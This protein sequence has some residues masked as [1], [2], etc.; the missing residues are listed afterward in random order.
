[1]KATPSLDRSVSNSSTAEHEKVARTPPP[2]PPPPPQSLGMQQKATAASIQIGLRQKE[3]RRRIRHHRRSI[4]EVWSHGIHLI[5]VTAAALVG[6]A[7]L[8][9]NEEAE[10]EQ[11]CAETHLRWRTGPKEKY[12]ELLDSLSARA[13]RSSTIHS[14]SQPKN[15]SSPYASTYRPS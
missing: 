2:P 9:H 8:N 11:Q 3:H 5:I 7:T 14:S 6:S 4:A 12:K 15:T 1:M 10:A 13:L